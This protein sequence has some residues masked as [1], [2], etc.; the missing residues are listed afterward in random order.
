[1]RAHDLHVAIYISCYGCRPSGQGFAPPQG[2]RP[3]L[4]GAAG[5]RAAPPPSAG[6]HGYGRGPPQQH[7]GR[8][9]GGRGGVGR[10]GGGRGRSGPPGGRAM[11]VNGGR[12]MPLAGRG[13]PMRGGFAGG[14]AGLSAPAAGA[15]QV[16]LRRQSQLA[17]WVR[18]LL[19]SRPDV[20]SILDITSIQPQALQQQC[21]TSIE[22]HNLPGDVTIHCCSAAAVRKE[23]AGSSTAGNAAATHDGECSGCAAVQRSREVGAGQVDSGAEGFLP[24][25]RQPGCQ[26]GRCRQVRCAHPCARQFLDKWLSSTAA[27]VVYGLV[28]P[29]E[30]LVPASCSH[31]SCRQLVLQARSHGAAGCQGRAAAAAQGGGGTAA[32]HGPR[33]GGTPADLHP[34]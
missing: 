16:R 1:M 20:T 28:V 18:P 29:P 13:P 25:H 14:R 17:A 34:H 32:R 31:K 24:L 4:Q 8:E 12:G 27:L 15:M 10:G 6:Q 19:S 23:E 22:V 5:P 30:W 26:A 2:P 11:L 33:Q 3:P 7:G 21:C 9:R